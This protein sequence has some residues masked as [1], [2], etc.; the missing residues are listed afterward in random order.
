MAV[1][2][3]YAL[4]GDRWLYCPS[5]DLQCHECES[6]AC[7]P[8]SPKRAGKRDGSHFP[9]ALCCVIIWLARSV[10]PLSSR[11]K[12]ELPN[13]VGLGHDLRNQSSGLETQ[14]EAVIFLCCL[15]NSQTV[16]MTRLKHGI[17]VV[18]P[19]Q[20]GSTSFCASCRCIT[21]YT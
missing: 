3:I 19:R 15:G 17:D 7:Q 20:A 8:P 6:T 5:S 21:T 1:N 12:R 16:S 11:S 4:F 18:S 13:V 10:L 14:E 2:P 9:E